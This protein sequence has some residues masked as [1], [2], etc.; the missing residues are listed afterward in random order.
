MG[1]TVTIVGREMLSRMNIRPGKIFST[2]Y[3]GL[4]NIGIRLPYTA[5]K[6]PGE[7]RIF[8]LVGEMVYRGVGKKKAQLAEMLNPLANLDLSLIYTFDE[9]GSEIGR[10]VLE[11]DFLR[12]FDDV[13][14]ML[15]KVP[16][17]EKKILAC[18]PAE[19]EPMREESIY[20]KYAPI[21]DSDGS[22][23]EKAML[24]EV[25]RRD[26]L[27]NLA[28]QIAQAIQALQLE[29]IGAK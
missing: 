7:S 17:L 21:A 23:A 25:F 6:L 12:E 27:N 22:V 4:K 10:L 26:K 28:K 11:A 16:G 29:I 20:W 24:I 18:F 19:S 5:G 8:V 14:R 3:R 9:E 1:S 15:Q 13:K 2:R